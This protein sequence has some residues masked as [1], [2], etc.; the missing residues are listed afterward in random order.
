[1]FQYLF[2]ATSERLYVR[3]LGTTNDLCSIHISGACPCAQYQG[4]AVQLLNPVET[5]S[6]K[7]PGFNP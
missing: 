3:E 2:S 1:M 5:H 4:G 7:P 6:L